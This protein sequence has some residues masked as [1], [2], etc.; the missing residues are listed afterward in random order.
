VKS[1]SISFAYAAAK[2]AFVAIALLV[3][4]DGGESL[5]GQPGKSLLAGP[6]ANFV[7]AE[8]PLPVPEAHFKDAN[9]KTLTLADFK[10]KVLLVNLWATWCAPCRREMP[11]LDKLQGML[12]SD[13]F[14]VIILS[15]DRGGFPKVNTFLEEIGVK[16]LTPY[17]D[18]STK[19]SRLFRAVGLP[20][21]FVVDRQ[22]R[23]VGRLIGPAEWAAPQSVA[24]LKFYIAQ[25]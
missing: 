21:T 11:E 6:V 18:K 3:A 15:Q 14:S 22:G 1:K 19:S 8:D 10:G 12:G 17:V 13:D 16:N 9:G 23:E 20:T 5:A 7:P 4:F 25:D 2:A 24:L